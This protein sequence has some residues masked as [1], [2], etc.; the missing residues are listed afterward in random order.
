MID[1]SIRIRRAIRLQ[2]LTL[3]K[4]IIKNNPQSLQNPD[5]ADQGNTS[6][7]LA[8]QLGLLDIAEF[9]IDAGHEDEGISKNANWDTPLSLAVETSEAVA[10]LLA[11]RF[12]R[13]IPWKNKQ[14]ADTL[15]LTSRT[16]HTTLL[17]H[18]LTLSTSPATSRPLAA[19]DT[20]GNTPLHYASAYG[21]LK[22]I[23]VL[24]EH[25]A[26][27][28]A[29]NAWSWTPVSYSASVQAEVYFKGLVNAAEREREREG[30]ATGTRARSREGSGTRGG[31]GA[32]MVRM[33]GAEEGEGF[34]RMRRSGESGR[35]RAGSGG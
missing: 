20:S 25:G 24:L 2:D 35:V 4:R 8:A 23:R 13:C 16:A 31:A 34:E 22:S 26:D 11:T 21:Q 18:L 30:M 32:G 28:S 27:A 1:V 12:P 17:T 19:A 10:T 9:L 33:V 3:L 5:F 7:H 15:M 14:G 6:L 29:R